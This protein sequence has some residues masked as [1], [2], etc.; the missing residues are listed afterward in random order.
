MTKT[1]QLHTALV[2]SLA[3]LLVI[4]ACGPTPPATT[5][6]QATAP[7]AGGCGDGTCDGPENPLNCPQD[8]P[9]TG[10]DSPPPSAC[11]LPNPQHAVVSE[12]LDVFQD[13]LTNA[14]FE[15]GEQD[16]Q[17]D[18]HPLNALS[19]AETT[20]SR[21]AARSGSWGYEVHAGPAQGATFSVQAYVDK[22]ETIRFTFWARSLDGEVTVQPVIAWNPDEPAPERP[23][24]LAAIVIGSEWTQISYVSET[25]SCTHGHMLWGLEV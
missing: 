11:A 21:A 12:D 4:S 22:G 9:T 15:S 14:S 24:S 23:A 2:T 13:V 18:N 3:I 8:C 25:T 20:R 1:T 5:Q 16:V 6:P 7:V 19:L 10:E 17:I